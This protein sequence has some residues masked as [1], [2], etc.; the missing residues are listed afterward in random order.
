MRSGVIFSAILH[1]I[2]FVVIFFGLPSVY[3]KK[4]TEQNAVVVEVVPIGEFTNI[5]PKPKVVPKAKPKVKPKVPTSK[6]ANVKPA[7]PDPKV[8]SKP[9]ISKPEPK[10]KAPKIVRKPK[11][12]PKVV[13]KDI[14]PIVRPEPPKKKE[15]VKKEVEPEPEAT[16]DSVLKTLEDIEAKQPEKKA[17]EEDEADFS[18]IEDM[19]NSNEE[20]EYKPGLPLS[21]T[22]KDAIINTVRNQVTKNWSTTSFSGAKDVH[23]MTATLIITLN[24]DGTVKDVEIKNLTKYHSDRIYKSIVDSARRAVYKSSPIK[25]LPAEKYAV[26]DGWREM[27][28]NFDPSQMM[29]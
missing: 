28:I 9:K 15:V 6:T 5:K 4:L 19:F 2:F 22:E 27:E 23:K 10:P 14:K 20:F 29:Y 17:V 26:K 16:F 8:K 7:K 11:P 21:I 24:Q 13:Q 18:D 12:E 3:E 25:N 1:V